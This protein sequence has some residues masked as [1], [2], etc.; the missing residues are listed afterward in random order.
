MQNN[1]CENENNYLSTGLNAERRGDEDTVAYM[2][3]FDV[4]DVGIDFPPYEE[5]PPPYSAIPK[6]LHGEA[7]PTYDESQRQQMVGQ[8]NNNEGEPAR[9]EM[10]QEPRGA[11][12][13][14]QTLQTQDNSSQALCEGATPA[15]TRVLD[16]NGNAVSILFFFLIILLSH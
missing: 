1:K 6:H 7:P 12:L 13:E 14:M 9:Q 4:V 8:H 3:H 11:V 5:R 2:S 16:R 10:Q 15:E